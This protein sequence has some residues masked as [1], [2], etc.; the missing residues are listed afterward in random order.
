MGKLISIL[1]IG[2]YSHESMLN[3]AE[4]ARAFGAMEIAFTGKE[5]KSIK[6]HI[7]ALNSK[8]GG[9]FS[10]LF[11][12]NYH[13]FINSKIHYK[14]VYL[15]RYGVQINKAIYTLRTYKNLLVIVTSKDVKSS[16]GKLADFSVSITAQPHSGASALAVFLHMFYEGRELAMHFENAKYKIA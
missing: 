4:T 5:D 10:V 11:I 2:N 13:E 14:K 8:W 1:V 6:R 9:K 3:I 7:S 15:T 12:K 16:V